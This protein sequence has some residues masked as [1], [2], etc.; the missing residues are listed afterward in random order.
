MFLNII[1]NLKPADYVYVQESLNRIKKN[2]VFDVQTLIRA[3]LE[4]DKAVFIL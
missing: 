2:M 3:E 1:K 4:F